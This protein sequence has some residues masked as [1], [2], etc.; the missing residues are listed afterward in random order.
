MVSTGLAAE[1]PTDP[2]PESNLRLIDGEACARAV[3]PESRRT[4]TRP[5]GGE[6]ADPKGRF[7]SDGE[8]ARG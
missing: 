3:A 1:R 2:F 6:S 7:G 4:G 5:K 8:L